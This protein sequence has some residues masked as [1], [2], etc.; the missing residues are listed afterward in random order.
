MPAMPARLNA[1]GAL[2]STFDEQRLAI[3]D[4]AID[5][6]ALQNETAVDYARVA[7]V[8]TYAEYAGFSTFN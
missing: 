8:A 3:N 2:N 6:F 5:L 1:I 7:G 4:L